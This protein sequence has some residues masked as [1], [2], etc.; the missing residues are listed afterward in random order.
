MDLS[1]RHVVLTGATGGLG[2]MLA[3]A[4]VAAGAEVALVA[5]NGKELAVMQAKLGSQTLVVTEDVSDVEANERI[6]DAV[7]SEWGGLDVW[8]ANAGISPVVKKP[9]DMTPEEFTNILSVNLFGAFWGARAALRVLGDGGRIIM[10]SSVLGQRARRGFSAY[11]ASKAGVEGL[12][13]A[14][15]L[16]TASSGITVNAIAPGWFD[17]PLTKTWMNDDRRAAEILS[18]VP[19]KRWGDA[20]DIVGAYMF[21]A[22]H[23]S[24]FVTGTVLA[25]DGGY[26]LQ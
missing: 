3:S 8:I 5:R 6:V 15:A 12:V 21:L 16:D 7:I 20:S 19:M 17:S 4:F 9:R 25:V 11:S 1:D 24:D 23:A 26:L 22:S 14:L 10:T 13:R 18:H 2:R